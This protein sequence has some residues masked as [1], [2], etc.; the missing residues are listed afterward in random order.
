MT[1]PAVVVADPPPPSPERISKT[2]IVTIRPER[3]AIADGG[4]RTADTTCHASGVVRESL[5]AG[6]MTRFVVSLD[7]GGELMVVRQNA[8]TSFE[9]AEN[10][11]GQAVTLAWGREYTRVIGTKEEDS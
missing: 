8:H 7:G 3:I 10:L 1:G 4:L 5:Y 6:P 11:R 2:A 9:D